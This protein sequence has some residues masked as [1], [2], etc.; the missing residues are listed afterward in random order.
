MVQARESVEQE[1]GMKL[2]WEEWNVIELDG[3]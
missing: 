3:S 1:R 2:E